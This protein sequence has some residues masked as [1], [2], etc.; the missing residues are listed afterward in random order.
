MDGQAEL[1]RLFVNQFGKI[2]R[3]WF[4]RQCQD[5]FAMFSKEV[6][7]W[8]CL[9]QYQAMIQSRFDPLADGV[10]HVDKV[11]NHSLL[12]QLVAPQ[13]YL[14][15]SIVSVQ[16]RTLASMP[17]QAMTVA[18]CK[19]TRNYKHGLHL[20]CMGTKVYDGSTANHR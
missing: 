3:R 14:Y 9:A 6:D 19:L 20:F 10:F 7:Q 2:F 5:R 16:I 13:L 1:F 11:G 18:K 17:S 4:D 8:I 12:I 15:C